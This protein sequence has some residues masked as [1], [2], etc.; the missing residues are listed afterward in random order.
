MLA[1]AVLAVALALVPAPLAAQ[2]RALISSDPGYFAPPS[3]PAVVGWTASD[4]AWYR[5]NRRVSA[6]GKVMT[7]LGLATA[8][9][10]ALARRDAV[11]PV[12]AGLV[13]Q[14]VGQLAWSIADLR[15]A[16]R[17]R[18]DGHPVGRAAGIVGVC[19][20]VLLSPVLWIAGPVQSAQIRR[21]H[22]ATRTTPSA[23]YG[24]AA[25]VAF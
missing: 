6:A 22:A 9:T 19:G 18:R 20:A 21:A 23:V 1:A 3:E 10:L 4:E 17:M 14:Q 5:R 7:V 24:L 16:T 12:V 15:A 13:V 8:T 25:S 11:V 2:R